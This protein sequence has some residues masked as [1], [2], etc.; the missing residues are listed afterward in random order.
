MDQV[1]HSLDTGQFSVRAAWC[2]CDL[3]ILEEKVSAVILGYKLWV[4]SILLEEVGVWL[5]SKIYP[6][7]A[8]RPLTLS[9]QCLK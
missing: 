1:A 5:S 6:C 8:I 7:G 4:L 9:M 2:Y 3:A